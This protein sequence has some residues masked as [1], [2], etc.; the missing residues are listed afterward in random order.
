MG[1][2]G[3]TTSQLSSSKIWSWWHT[4]LV[5]LAGAVEVPSS[6][7]IFRNVHFT[8]H[9]PNIATR[10]SARSAIMW[11]PVGWRTNML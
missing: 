1:E 3:I 9:V 11:Y 7:F 5:L 10:N 6:L 8:E 4:T 2:T